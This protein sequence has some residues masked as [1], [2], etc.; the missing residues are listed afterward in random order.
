MGSVE[1]KKE[2]VDQ[3]AK[4]SIKQQCILLCLARSSYYYQSKGESPQ[5]EEIMKLMDRGYSGQTGHPF[6][7]ESE[8]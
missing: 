5:N 3:E 6:P 7:D 8:Q 2:L 4:L 1:I